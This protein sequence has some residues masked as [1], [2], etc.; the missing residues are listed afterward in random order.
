MQ[1]NNKRLLTGA[2]LA[3]IIIAIT[4]VVIPHTTRIP[5][6]VSLMYFILL[7][8]K[9]ITLHFGWPLANKFQAL[10]RIGVSLLAFACL[11]GIYISFHRIVGRDPG[12]ALLV[13]LAAFK[14]LEARFERDGYILICVGFILTIT[15]FFY[16]ESIPIALFMIAATI[17]LTSCFIILN[18]RNKTFSIKKNLKLSSSLL[19]LSLPVM[20]ILFVFFPRVSGPLWKMPQDAH[21][22]KT[23]ITDRMS[24]GSISK[25][26]RSNA[27]AF[28]VEFYD[29]IPGAE[30]MY[31]RGPVL[32]RTDGRTWT[33][34]LSLIKPYEFDASVNSGKT[35]YQI[36]MEATNKPW[37]YGLDTVIKS[38]MGVISHDAQLVTKKVH[39]R[40]RY[41]ATSS[42]ALKRFE[43][44]EK[45]LEKSLQLPETHHPKARAMVESW[46]QQG[47][48]DNQIIEQAMD[49]FSEQEF[50]Y[51]L[52]PPLLNNDTVDEFLFETR[53]GFCEHYASAFVVLM[54]AA[55]IPARV[56]TGYQGATK[57][58]LG[59]H[60]NIFQRDA[61]AWAEVYLVDNGWTRIDPTTAVAPQRII[62]GI[63]ESV[64][65]YSSG[66]IL[67]F[68][69]NSLTYNLMRNI[70]NS[71]DTI[72]YRWNLWVLG[73][74]D[75]HQLKILKRLGIEDFSWGALFSLITA[76]FIGLVL[77]LALIGLFLFRNHFNRDDP[78]L[79]WYQLF[80]KKLSKIGIQ[81]SLQEGP[82][83]FCNRVEKDLVD[84]E[85]NVREITEQY[86]DVRYKSDLSNLQHFKK[87]VQQFKPKL[88]NS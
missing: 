21:S 53:Q 60:F 72:N 56:V 39:R 61:H 17:L 22:A 75:E 18:D 68:D 5:V 34:D 41:M 31:W 25:L 45:V 52:Q 43:S 23:G 79:Y 24:P 50:Y 38:E 32:T 29:Q 4:F 87:L 65:D 6:W 3:W 9:L 12:V 85:P 64:A 81:R 47:L 11:F 13:V 77:S 84:M 80:C 42:I 30:N 76:L 71:W 58:P 69:K 10:F 82:V 15:N 26:S 67:A 83:D 59:N 74:N 27:L 62:Q 8:W 54:R 51:T 70:R 37:L 57:N 40:I 16:D 28:R 1:T 44:N 35:D 33:R 49:M 78:A 48:N 19:A 63:E 7:S 73:Y 86:I 55:G 14:I 46:K 2:E 66:G 88:I 36:T 20:L